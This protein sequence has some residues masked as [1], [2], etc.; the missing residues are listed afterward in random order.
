[1]SGAKRTITI[2]GCGIPQQGVI[3]RGIDRFQRVTDVAVTAASDG[4]SRCGDCAVSIDFCVTT[5][6][7]GNVLAG[8]IEL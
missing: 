8:V 3:Q 5:Q 2:I 1:M 7:I 4:I 6:S